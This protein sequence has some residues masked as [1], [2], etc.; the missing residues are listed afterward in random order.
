[1]PLHRLTNLTLAGPDLEETAAFYADFGLIPDPTSGPG[2][3]WL[4][5]VDGG[6]RQLRL[7]ER[8]TRKPVAIGIGADGLEDLGRIQATLKGLGI[9][10][11]LTDGSLRSVDPGSGLE[12]TVSVAAPIAARPQAAPPYNT[13]GFV[14]RANARADA[15]M[16]SGPVRPRKLG[17]IG[18]G[19]MDMAAS[20]R[21]FV[22]GLGF[23]VSDV[24]KDLDAGEDRE[25]AIFMR[26]STEHHNLVLQ[27]GPV[28]FL[29]HSSWELE[30]FDEIGRGAYN[31][32]AK[33][34][35]CHLWGLGRHY[36]ASNFFY[37]FRDPT[38]HI[39]EYYGDM[40]HILDAAEWNPE[41]V[42]VKV[43]ATVWGPRPMPSAVMEPDDL[44]QLVAAERKLAAAE[45]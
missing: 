13:P 4:G 21:F 38:G 37:Y 12:V 33:R 7:I 3:R 29:G 39:C 34:P 2:E 27:P 5:T 24:V 40:D 32:L 22:D 8:P 20:R 1:M 42:D 30:D 43:A 44:A 11:R 35:D 41:A 31:L 14:D 36:V 17:H 26:C 9:A 15:L 6:S 45:S 10:S 28:I 19:T 16:R 25:L 18:L 23:E